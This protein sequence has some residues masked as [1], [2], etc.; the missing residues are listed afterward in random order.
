MKQLIK[1]ALAIVGLSLALLQSGCGSKSSEAPA[2][3]PTKAAAEID[4]PQPP[5]VAKCEPGIRGGRLVI[6]S[7]ADPKTF[8]PI[9]ANETSSR[10]IYNMMFDGLVKKNQVTQDPIPGLAASWEVAADQKTWTFHL[11]K[12]LKWSD[13]HPLTADDV[14]FTFNDVVYNTNIVNVTADP[15]RVGGK[16]FEVSKVDDLTVRIVTAEIFAPFV[17]F[18]G[19]VRILPQHVL[20]SAVKEKR[21]ESAYGVNTPPDQLVVSGAYL[22][23][24][25]KP[26][27]LALLE[28]NPY[29][30][31]VD[32]KGQRLPYFD[33]VVHLVVPD[34]NTLAL[35]FLKGES[36]LLE[37]V[38]PEEADKFKEASANGRFR[39]L[40]LGVA[41]QFDLIIFNENTGKN[42]AGKPYIAPHKLKWFRNQKFRQAISYALDREAIVRATLSGHGTPFYG[43]F[44]SSN[45]KWYNPKVTQYP[46]DLEKARQLLAEIGIKDRNGDGVL[47]DEQGN[48]IEFELNTNTG[49]SR[50]EKGSVIVQEDLKRL[51]IKVNFR[52]LEFNSLVTKLDASFDFECIFLGLA[53]ESVDPVESMNVIKSSGFS[54]QWF[55]RQKT[56]AT[57]WEA[58]LDWLMDAQL[59]T[60]D[61]AERKKYVDEVQAILAEQMPQIPT[62]AMN[63]YAAIRSD[64]GNVNATVHHNNRLVW[65][66]EELYFKK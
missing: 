12:G 10:D 64:I 44:T 32:S 19:D 41:S 66:V 39:L 8:N 60:L 42:A 37:F 49:N 46:H 53:S 26:G 35:R 31:K 3:G 27:Q 24:Q 50:R 18:A 22:L 61:F 28:R 9:T 14:V 1:P 40:D 33:S 7:F 38:R 30:Y 15:L 52:P 6:A 63:A 47:E 54:H 48:P 21:F 56:P 16:N 5:L 13:G 55:P 17:E 59:K 62:S 25:Y 34:Q 36:D 2:A 23:K 45:T 43:F 51:G 11:R 4:L 20:A 57:E 65:N 58:R 29:Y